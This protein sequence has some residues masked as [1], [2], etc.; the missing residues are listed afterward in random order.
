MKKLLLAGLTAGM[1]L[2][3][4]VQAQMNQPSG[5]T[6][7]GGAGSMQMMPGG[8]GGMM[9]KP[10][11]EWTMQDMMRMMQ[12]M[13]GMMGMGAMNNLTGAAYDK[14]FVQGML[15]H[16]QEVTERSREFAQ[17][18]KDPR[19]K[20]WAARII[21]AQQDELRTLKDLNAEL[22]RAQGT[23]KPG[24]MS[25][26]GNA[27]GGMNN[28]MGMNSMMGTGGMS[29][30]MGMGGMSMRDSN[31]PGKGTTADPER[32]YVKYVIAHHAAALHMASEALRKSEDARIL[33]LAR[34]ILVD[35]SRD[36]L[37]MKAWLKRQ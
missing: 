13:H 8:M 5:S 35:Q 9:T 2:G 21:K 36:V 20:A 7:P 10:M 32:E 1:V 11:S 18:A 28:G 23:A 31:M 24:G 22:G 17:S 3:G 27:T 15:E 37:E 12:M 14:A 26:P 4:A 25:T 19:V 34:N 6:M 16:H 33:Q 30:M 29:G